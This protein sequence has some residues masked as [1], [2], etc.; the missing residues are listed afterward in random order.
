MAEYEVTHT[1]RYT[2][3]EKVN[4]CQNIAYL[5]PQSDSR[6]TCR[7][8]SVFVS[9][10][11]T[12]LNQHQDY[13]GNKYYYFSVEEAHS[14]LEVVGKTQVITMPL[15]SV[16][17]IY[18]PAWEDAVAALKNP[19]GEA[20]IRA[21]EFVLAS[22]FIPL[23]DMFAAFARETFTPGRPILQAA[24]DFSMRIY[25]EFKYE[26]KS[27]NILTPLA[28][29]YQKRTGVCQDFAHLCIAAL[30]SI[31]LAAQYTSGYIETF[32]PKDKPKLRGSDASHAWFAI[33]VPGQG[34]FDFDPTNGK[35]I[36]E[37]FIVTARGRDFG[38]VSP[39]KGILFGGGKHTLKVEVDVHRIG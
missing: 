21:Q 6:Q 8:S 22:A 32:P 34:W 16:A 7:N 19:Q 11:P 15:Q 25:R 2:Y 37:E 9:P 30:R 27:T 28:E 24:L 26:Q 1:T 23:S 31:G 38:D 35:A 18:S 4:H 3:T 33:Y 5:A 14:A 29:V 12:I 39:L 13:F 10:Y 17:D 36:S 20:D